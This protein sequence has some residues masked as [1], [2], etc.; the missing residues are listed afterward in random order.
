MEPIDRQEKYDEQTGELYQAI[1]KCSVKFE[2][3]TLAM[4]QAIIFLLHKGGLKNQRLA[5]VLLADLTA[6]PLKS[7][8]QAMVP[9]SSQ[10]SREEQVI[11]DKIFTRTQK[12]I[13][14]RND[15]I[16]STWFVGWAS[17]S[18]TD[19]SEVTGMKQARGKRGADFKA[20]KHT[21]AEFE[22]FAQEC[23]EVAKLLRGLS[24]CVTSDFQIAKNFLIDVNGNVST[25]NG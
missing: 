24:A 15:I 6:Y 11:C 10:L 22:A 17:S 8:F 9:E 2:H 20:F 4:Q 5:N 21:A 12:L 14:Q 23:D 1:G 13:E 18:D 25:P 3:V 19:F 16:H 7:I